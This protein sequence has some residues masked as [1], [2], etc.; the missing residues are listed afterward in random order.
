MTQHV[1][2]IID[3]EYDTGHLVAER[4]GPVFKFNGYGGTQ[5]W[6]CEGCADNGRFGVRVERKW[7]GDRWTV[8]YVA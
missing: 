6:Y 7:D 4:L 2:E 8:W 1:R 3:H 5:S